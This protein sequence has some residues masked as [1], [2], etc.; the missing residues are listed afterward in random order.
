MTDPMFKS[1]GPS[2]HTKSGLIRDDLLV[3]LSRDDLV[4]LA[5]FADWKPEIHRAAWKRRRQ[6]P[7]GFREMADVSVYSPRQESAVK[8]LSYPPVLPGEK[9]GGVKGP[10]KAKG[11]LSRLISYRLLEGTWSVARLTSKGRAALKLHSARINN[12]QP[13]DAFESHAPDIWDDHD[14]RPVYLDNTRLDFVDKVMKRVPEVYRKASKGDSLPDN[15]LTWRIMLAEYKD[16]DYRGSG[17][18]NGCTAILTVASGLR[19]LNGSLRTHHSFPTLR[20]HDEANYEV[21]EVAMS[22]EALAELLVGNHNVPV[23]IDSYFGPDGMRRCLPVPEPVS[24]TRRVHE[25]VKRH[26]QD[27]LGWLEEA[28]QIVQEGRMGKKLQ[29]AIIEK[30]EL[31]IRDVGSEGAYTAHMAMEEVSSVAESLLTIMVERTGADRPLLP[32]GSTVTPVLMLGSDVEDAEVEVQA[33]DYQKEASRSADGLTDPDEGE[34]APTRKM[35]EDGTLVQ[36]VTELDGTEHW[37]RADIVGECWRMFADEPPDPENPTQS[38]VKHVA[39]FLKASANLPWPTA[40]SIAQDISD[41]MNGY[42]DAT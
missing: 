38:Q 28:K 18:L 16:E 27:S 8:D 37:V 14:L 3:P 34:V 32:D 30:L 40:L 13:P 25:R 19:P 5:W 1:T 39:A 20:I 12:Y 17:T 9:A 6:W 4:V 29:A 26:R 36:L 24:I 31:A 23:T 11:S 15:E 35:L 41:D 21:V 42:K 10:R 33:L 22:Y 7:P 2:E